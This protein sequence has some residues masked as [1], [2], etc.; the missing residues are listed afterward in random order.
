MYRPPIV[1]FDEQTAILVVMGEE[2]RLS[3][4]S[5][6]RAISLAIKAR[7]DVVVDLTGLSFADSSLMIDLAVLARRL[8]QDGRNLRLRGAQPQVRRLIE[9]MG[10]HR[11]PAIALDVA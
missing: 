2:D 1:S 4:G 9:L 7:C 8:R 3:S 6:R 5:R 10:V 11:L